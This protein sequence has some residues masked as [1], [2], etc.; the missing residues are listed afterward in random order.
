M[1]LE[2]LKRCGYTSI[3]ITKNLKSKF[4]NLNGIH[5]NG[6]HLTKSGRTAETE[7]ICTAHQ[8]KEKD[9]VGRFVLQN[10]PVFCVVGRSE[11][12]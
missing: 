9:D 1:G 8:R 7:G 2:I 6:M 11:E 4:W 3:L 10:L 5:L 12:T